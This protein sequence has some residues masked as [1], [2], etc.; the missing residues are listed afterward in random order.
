MM[1]IPSGNPAMIADDPAIALGHWGE[2]SLAIYFDSFDD[3]D[4]VAYSSSAS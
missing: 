1:F 4:A 3:V 2:R